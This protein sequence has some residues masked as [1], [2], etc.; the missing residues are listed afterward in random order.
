MHGSMASVNDQ[1]NFPWITTLRENL[2]NAE[3]HIPI[4]GFCFGA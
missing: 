4:L 3:G 2:K 1:E